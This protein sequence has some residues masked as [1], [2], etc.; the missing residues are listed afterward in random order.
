MLSTSVATAGVAELG[1][2]RTSAPPRGAATAQF[3]DRSDFK[4]VV[5]LLETGTIEGPDGKIVEGKYMKYD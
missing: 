5:K 1:L 3:G 2:R 4:E